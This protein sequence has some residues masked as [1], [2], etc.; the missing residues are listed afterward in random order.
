ML[1]GQ[2]TLYDRERDWLP[3]SPRARILSGVMAR[4]AQQW[5]AALFPELVSQLG[6]RFKGTVMTLKQL[7]LRKPQEAEALGYVCVRR[8][9][10]NRATSLWVHVDNLDEL[11]AVAA[12]VAQ[13]R[14]E[15]AEQAERQHTERARA[16]DELL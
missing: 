6:D 14:A 4:T 2:T 10:P 9:Q 13:L 3:N 16:V 7:G 5:E 11:E 15:R 8:A 12:D 1:T